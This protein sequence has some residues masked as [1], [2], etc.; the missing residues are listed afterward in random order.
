MIKKTDKGTV[1][2]DVSGA[3]KWCK[4]QII[5]T[6]KIFGLMKTWWRSFESKFT[7]YVPDKPDLNNIKWPRMNSPKKEYAWGGERPN[8]KEILRKYIKWKNS[9][10]PKDE[11]DSSL[12]MNSEFLLNL[13]PELRKEYMSELIKKRNIAHEVDLESSRTKSI[14]SGAARSYG[15]IRAE[16]G[17]T[18]HGL[19]ISA[20]EAGHGLYIKGEH[21]DTHFRTEHFSKGT[22]DLAAKALAEKIMEVKKPTTD[23]IKSILDKWK[24]LFE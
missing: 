9:P 16:G 24:P 18:G 23:D 3:G 11:F 14:I 12:N 4:S 22:N 7:P 17:A 19:Y 5:K 21:R 6:P 15:G 13:E 10:V 20:N 2:I 8:K 1:Q